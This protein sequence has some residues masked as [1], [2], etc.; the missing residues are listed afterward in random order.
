MSTHPPPGKDND[1]DKD[2]DK[3]ED[4]EDDLTLLI[5]SEKIDI[6]RVTE[7]GSLG[8]GKWGYDNDY[9][10]LSFIKSLLSSTSFYS[11]LS[12]SL[13]ATVHTHPFSPSSP[14]YFRYERLERLVAFFCVLRTQISKQ[15]NRTA[16]WFTSYLKLTIPFAN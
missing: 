14:A 6:G 10:E 11:P 8:V 1:N 16:Y 12:S 2:K 15:K 13:S 4:Y 3:E 7:V 9:T 5:T